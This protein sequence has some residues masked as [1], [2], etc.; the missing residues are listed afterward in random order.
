MDGRIELG[1]V[2]LGHQSRNFDC[3]FAGLGLQKQTV[4]RKELAGSRRRSTGQEQRSRAERQGHLGRKLEFIFSCFAAVARLRR[5]LSVDWQRLG[6]HG[7]IGCF[8]SNRKLSASAV[9]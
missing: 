6:A 7:G 2:Y 3:S 4:S 1:Q 8:G 9:Q 5:C